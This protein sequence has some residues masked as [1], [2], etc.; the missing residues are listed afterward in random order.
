MNHSP[1]IFFREEGVHA[2]S[3]VNGLPVVE[4]DMGT[5][6]VEEV[7]LD[8]AGRALEHFKDV[9]GFDVPVLGTM[10]KDHLCLDLPEGDSC[11][12]ART[13]CSPLKLGL[14]LFSDVPNRLGGLHW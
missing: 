14:A 10:G 13:G 4:V 3:E 11:G 2:F 8:V 7:F 12:H 9:K 1:A 6:V 5:I